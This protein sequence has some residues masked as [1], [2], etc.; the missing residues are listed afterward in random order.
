[1]AITLTPELEAMV[2]EDASSWGFETVEAYLEDRLTAMHESERYLREHRE[3]ISAM[4]DEGLE[5]SYRGEL[6]TPE[7]AERIR[8]A[9][10]REFLVQRDAA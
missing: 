4:I 2:T 5:E 9:A 7:K 10:K 6:L 1:M 8:D 3:E